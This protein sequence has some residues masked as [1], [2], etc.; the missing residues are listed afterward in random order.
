MNVT[1]DHEIAE[2]PAGFQGPNLTPAGLELIPRE[3][4]PGVHALMANLPPKDNSGVIAGADA[5]LVIDAGI[6][7]QVARHIRSLAAGLTPAPVRY[8][9]NTTYHGDHT[10]GNAAFP[11]DVT[12][13]SHRAN[14]DAMTD[15]GREKAM[16][17]ES[18]Y[19]DEALLDAVTTWRRPDLVFDS[20]CEID[21]GGG[22]LAALHWFGQGNG[23]GD[24]VVHVP[25]A[26]TAWTGNFVAVGGIA[27]LLQG[28]PGP[29]LAAVRRMRDA[30]PGLEWIVPGHGP[31][32]SAPV[33]LAELITYLERLESEVA[34]AVDAGLTLEE[35]Y[36]RCTDPFEHGLPDSLLGGLAAYDLPQ[37]I[38][39]TRFRHAVREL[40]RL[41]VLVTY[42][43]RTGRP[44][45]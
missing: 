26:R 29:Y 11:A 40:H 16:R 30:L 41:N 42:R 6:T 18:M 2:R 7:P 15:L 17:A 13:V 44:A 35:T 45:R 43:V 28:G 23:P 10:F 5:A 9:V 20:S 22:Q 34:E 33:A 31:I 27:M 37:E 8:L 25:S 32:G 24:T 19:G 14:R 38:A 4:A 36:A 12:I 1:F 21:L 3:L 39:R